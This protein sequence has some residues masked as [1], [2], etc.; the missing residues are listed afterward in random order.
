MKKLTI[1]MAGVLAALA[2]AALPAVATAGTFTADC[3]SGAS[4]SA[5]I[6]G[7]IATLN[8]T[9][10]EKIECSTTEGTATQTN[11]SSAGT[12]ELTFKGCKEKI[13]GFNFACN[14]TGAASGVIT[15]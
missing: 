11:A 14:S 12:T 8:N 3:A 9:S 6:A 2:V 13:S 7:G 5:T 15:T 10:G 1:L 4:C